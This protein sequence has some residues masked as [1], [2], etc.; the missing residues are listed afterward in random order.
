ML[1]LTSL[2]AGKAHKTVP[3]W[4]LAAGI[5]Q[6]LGRVASR[7]GAQSLSLLVAAPCQVDSASL[8]RYVSGYG[9]DPEAIERHQP[10]LTSTGHRLLADLVAPAVADLLTRVATDPPAVEE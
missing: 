7:R 2:P 8:W 3:D 5:L 10:N 6:D 4:S 1:G 9:L